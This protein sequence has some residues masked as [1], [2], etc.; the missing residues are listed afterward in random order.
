MTTTTPEY[1]G[2]DGADTVT[3]NG[4][5][6]GNLWVHYYGKAGDDKITWSNGQV[7]GGAGNDTIIRAADDQSGVFAAYWD[8]PAGI[9][10][11]L[12]AGYA[13]DGW[14]SR[15]TL[16]NIRFVSASGNND[17]I[18]GSSQDDGFNIGWGQDYVDGR[19]GFDTVRMDGVASDW[20]IRVSVDG[21]SIFIT[22]KQDP[23]TRSSEL[24]NIESLGFYNQTEVLNV[25][26]LIDSSQKGPQTLVASPEQRWNSGQDLGSA[27]TL[28]YSFANTVPSYGYG[29][30]GT[31]VRSWTAS[32]Q[33]AVRTLLATLSSQTQLTFTEVADSASTY[34]QIRFGINVQSGTAAYSYSPDSSAGELAGDIWLSSTTALGLGAGGSGMPALMR[35]IGHALGLQTPLT[36]TYTGPLPIL[37]DAEN[38]SHY[39]V[40]SAASVSGVLPREGFGVY[41]LSA[42]RYLYGTRAAGTGDTSY[43]FTDANGKTQKLIVDDLGV[44]SF[45]ASNLSIGANLDLREGKQSSIGRDAQ[46]GA[47]VENVAI[48]F[49]TVIVNATGTRFDDVITGNARDN[50][51]SGFGGNNII[52]GGAG[53]DSAVYRGKFADYAV[54][55]SSYSGKLIVAA[56]NGSDGSDTLSNIETL[57]FSD[58]SL[59]VSAIG[60]D[61][62]DLKLD[63]AAHGNLALG[64]DA[65]NT[66]S[67]SGGGNVIDGASGTDT[68]DYA[69]K[70]ADFSVTANSAGTVSVSARA[71]GAADTLL[72]IER[73]KFSDDTLAITILAPDQLTSDQSGSTQ[74]T[75]V[76]GN[77]L[78]N[79]LTGTRFDDILDGGAGRDL[80]SFSGARAHF[81]VTRTADGFT[82]KDQTGAEGNDSLL[83]IERIKFGDTGYALDYDGIAGQAYRIYQAAFN[84]TPDSGGLGFWISQMDKGLSVTVV[85]GGFVDSNEFKA[86]FG[87]NPSNAQIVDKFYQNVLHR[88][89]EA[90]GVAFYNHVLDSGAATVAEV[91]ASF[92][93]SPENQAALVGVIGNG[94]AYTPFG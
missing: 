15:D 76:L 69:G 71:G 74:G 54:S 84:R 22:N 85:A 3:R 63:S 29:S 65:D 50:V 18:Y 8:S 16:V 52:D 62:T 28:T 36:S 13:L 94:F 46:D 55:I 38:D 21:R 68:A 77:D 40:M 11:D 87:S 79:L 58:L 5:A 26:D 66:I 6:P 72:N 32:E 82:V 25:A 53:T 31:S 33:A 35:E 30:G 73:V 91:L 61:Q 45:D 89:G 86:L 44:N 37:I 43:R 4:I 23:T 12:Q 10:V 9:Y 93:E 1:F 2:T 92:S 51:L 20:N 67:G 41:D 90:G 17:T 70:L 48:G 42:L 81:S 88:A 64:N 57:R 7:I 60:A 19:D 83:H 75:L 80:V 24:H 39:T 47:A 14:G 34:G 49:G 56:T 27:V 78:A 59:H